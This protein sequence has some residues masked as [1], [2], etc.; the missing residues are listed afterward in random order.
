MRA[1]LVQEELLKD[2]LL[3]LSLDVA[4]LT[5]TSRGDKRGGQSQ[6]P[7]THP[8]HLLLHVVMAQPPSCLKR[9]SV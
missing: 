2:S 1:L 6:G 3:P 8:G 4:L 5:V 7:G 9:V